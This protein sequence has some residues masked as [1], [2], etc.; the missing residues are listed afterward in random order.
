LPLGPVPD[1]YELITGMAIADGLLLQEEISFSGGKSGTK[2]TAITP[3]GITL[4][5][6][7]E[8]KIMDFI[9]DYFKKYTSEQIK[10]KSHTE[11]G[12]KETTQGQAISYKYAQFLSIKIKK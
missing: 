2:Y 9:I 3:P 7:E 5:N 10:E 4:F 8:I 6:G 11:K 12:Y 1:K